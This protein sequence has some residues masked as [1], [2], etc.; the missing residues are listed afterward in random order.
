MGKKL[1]KRFLLAAAICVACGVSAVE[2]FVFSA[3]GVTVGSSERELPSQGFDRVTGRVV[4]GL[5]V[6]TDLER[7][8]CGWWRVIPTERPE[9]QS[10]EVW[11]VGGYDFGGGCATQKWSCTW[12]KVKPVKYSRLSIYAAL[13]QLGKWETAETWMKEQGLYTA[14]MLAQEISSDHPQFVAVK[15]QVAAVLGLTDAQVDAILK[16]CILK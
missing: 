4:V 12:R 5:H 13:S 1:M 7:A 9:A 2:R 6:R 11:R 10:N 15:S 3:D 8:A 16:E 14:F